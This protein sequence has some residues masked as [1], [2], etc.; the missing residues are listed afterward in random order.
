MVFSGGDAIRYPI[1]IHTSGSS[2]LTGVQIVKSW[3]SFSVSLGFMWEKMKIDDKAPYFYT[4]V[5]GD[6]HIPFP[7]FEIV[8]T[9][10]QIGLTYLF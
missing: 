10:G 5:S 7:E 6:V 4:D 3:E 1:C 2:V 8:Q 9:V